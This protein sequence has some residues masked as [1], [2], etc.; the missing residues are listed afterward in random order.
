M[1]L[2]VYRDSYYK[3]HMGVDSSDCDM[4]ELIVSKDRL[5]GTHGQVELSWDKEK[6]NYRM[7]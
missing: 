7:G 2:F 3:I 4:A 5:R 1:V 6:E